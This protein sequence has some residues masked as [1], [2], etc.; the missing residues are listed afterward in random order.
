MIV[1]SSAIGLLPRSRSSP[2]PPYPPKIAAYWAIPRRHDDGGGDGRRD[3]ADENVAVFDVRQLVRDNAF[4][5]VLAEDLQNTL[6]R[7][8]RGVRRIA[9]GGE[10]VGRRIRNHVNLRHRQARARDEPFDDGVQRVAWT[11]L[12][13]VVHPQDDLVRKPV[14][15]EV[16]E[17][18]EHER[19]HEPVRPAKQVADDEQNA[20]QES[21]QQGGFQS[22]GHVSILTVNRAIRPHTSAARHVRSDKTTCSWSAWAPSPDGP[23]PSN[24]GTPIAAVKFPSEPPPAAP[25]PRSWPSSLATAFA[26][27]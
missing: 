16:H 22:V 21:Q 9:A 24:V 26:C 15:P 18:C 27:S 5:L 11:D 12:L 7:R 14:R 1:A 10:G 4:E 6:R 8:N 25:S 20:A 3:G 13:R 2:R 23:R 17:H 19:H